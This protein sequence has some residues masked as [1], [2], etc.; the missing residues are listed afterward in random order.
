VLEERVTLPSTVAWTAL[1]KSESV[2]ESSIR[3]LAMSADR[4]N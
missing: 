1:S 4:N 3:M 2:S